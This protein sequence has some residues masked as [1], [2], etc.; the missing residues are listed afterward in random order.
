MYAC[1]SM[2]MEQYEKAR[3]GVNTSKY[4]VVESQWFDKSDKKS[5]PRPKV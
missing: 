1:V 5:F 3:V 4:A 2:S